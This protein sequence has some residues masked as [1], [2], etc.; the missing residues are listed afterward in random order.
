MF[1]C[2]VVV[3]LSLCLLLF[4]LDNLLVGCFFS[5]ELFVIVVWCFDLFFVVFVLVCVLLLIVLVYCI[6]FV[7]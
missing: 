6:V 3:L 5:G 2:F 7:S 4:A 1:G